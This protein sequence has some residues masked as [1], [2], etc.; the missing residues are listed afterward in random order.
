MYVTPSTQI[1]IN[2]GNAGRHH[3]N[4]ER[5]KSLRAWN[6]RAK[7]TDAAATKATTPDTTSTQVLTSSVFIASEMAISHRM[8]PTTNPPIAATTLLRKIRS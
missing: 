8:W 1:V 4:I 2:T 7:S 6:F 5:T 3:K